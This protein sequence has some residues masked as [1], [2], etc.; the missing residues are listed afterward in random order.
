M[1][2]NSPGR[3]RSESESSAASLD[4]DFADD[5]DC[6]VVATVSAVPS[7]TAKKPINR[8]LACILGSGESDSEEEEEEEED[9]W[10]E[11]CVT[12]SAGVSANGLPDLDDSWETFGLEMIVLQCRKDP[13][14]EEC[15]S[16]PGPE[17]PEIECQAAKTDDQTDSSNLSEINA[18]WEREVSE[19]VPVKSAARVRFGGTTVH[20]MVVWSHAYRKARSGPWEQQAR[21]RA[22][23]RQRIGTVEAELAPILEAS[24]RTAVYER[25]F[26]TTTTTT[27]PT[28]GS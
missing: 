28:A 8:F 9:D 10:D 11:V 2:P 14:K 17:V 26:G 16:E 1:T 20:P 6:A 7:A 13:A 5:V 19:G 18:R 15:R 25:L 27:T 3:E 21:D 12:D 24:H 23:F 22:R 4:I